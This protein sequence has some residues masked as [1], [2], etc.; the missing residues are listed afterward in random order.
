MP[1]ASTP[2][3]PTP[4]VSSA[5]WRPA[6]SQ[7]CRPR[8]SAT[9]SRNWRSADRP[10]NNRWLS[11]LETQQWLVQTHYQETRQLPQR[12]GFADQVALHLIAAELAQQR[13]LLGVFH[14][15]AD[16]LQIE[17]V[18]QV[19]HRPHQLAIFRALAHAADKALVDLQ[20]GDRQAVE[21]HERR[22]T[23][24]EVVQGKAHAQTREGQHGLL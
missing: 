19:D 11:E 8:P 7:P 23:G 2:I 5:G 6:R 9:A 21:V 15:L 13:Q 1:S 3:W 17:V 22:E 14:A 20:Q 12:Q 4:T 10:R 16:H 24:A 18:R